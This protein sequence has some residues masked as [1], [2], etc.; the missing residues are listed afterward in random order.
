MPTPDEPL[1]PTPVELPPSVEPPPSTPA[2][3]ALPATGEQATD[4]S[5]AEC[6]AQLAERF[7]AVFAAGAAKPLK[8]RIQADIQSRAPG[9]FTRRALS[10]FL[11]RHTTSNAY[12]KALARAAQR[13]DLDGQPAG[14]LADEH[15]QAAIAELERRRGIHHDKRRAQIA[16][17]REQQREARRAESE[18]EGRARAE[19]AALLRAH[20]V[21][22]LTRKNF[23]ALKGVDEAQLDALLAQARL[24]REQQLRSVAPPAGP[25]GPKPRVTS[26]GPRAGRPGR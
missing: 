2:E 6:A 24:E 5:P 25:Q 19:R 11:H 13:V 12:L 16:A 3:P 17:Q 14:D 8:L 10:A 26:S 9:V 23:C 15:R 7:P 1:P 4:L 18:A 20:E 21:S 22:T